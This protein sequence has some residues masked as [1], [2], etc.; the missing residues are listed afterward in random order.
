MKTLSLYSHQRTLSRPVAKTAIRALTPPRPI[1]PS[2]IALAKGDLLWGVEERAQYVYLVESGLVVLVHQDRYGDR[3]RV[4]LIGP[5]GTLGETALVDAAPSGLTAVALVP[6]TV[7]TLH[8]SAIRGALS[9][10]LTRTLLATLASRTRTQQET[11]IRLRRQGVS[12][13]L[14]HVLCELSFYHPNSKQGP[15][16]VDAQ[17]TQLDLAL[18]TWTSRETICAGLGSFE[19]RGWIERSAQARS[20]IRIFPE[21]GLL[22]HAQR[23]AATC[24]SGWPSLEHT[25]A[26]QTALWDHLLCSQQAGPWCSPD[27][28]T[29]PRWSQKPGEGGT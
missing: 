11:V 29:G 10:A 2:T 17:I 13:R 25:N 23:G 1:T 8:V 28:L 5:G 21:R 26:T 19:Q 14:A 27:L 18:L 16:L 22:A 3:R 15:A 20:P 4:D 12:P 6:S 7:L 9:P 24:V